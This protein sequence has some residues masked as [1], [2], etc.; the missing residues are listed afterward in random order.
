MEKPPKTLQELNDAVLYWA[1]KLRKAE[2]TTVGITGKSLS[3]AKKAHHSAK[4]KFDDAVDAL[5]RRE[6]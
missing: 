6:S 4:M 3:L 2:K 5:L 1:V